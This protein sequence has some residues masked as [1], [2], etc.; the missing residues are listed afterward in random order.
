MSVL[1]FN[2]YPAADYYNSLLKKG[3]EAAM[4]AIAEKKVFHCIRGAKTVEEAR[5][6]RCPYSCKRDGCIQ[7]CGG[8]SVEECDDPTICTKIC[9]SSMPQTVPGKFNEPDCLLARVMSSA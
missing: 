7:C 1:D 8:G 3:E 5:A 2:P 4:S 9:E 6:I